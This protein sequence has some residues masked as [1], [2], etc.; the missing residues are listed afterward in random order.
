MQQ[1]DLG[2]YAVSN[3]EFIGRGY[4]HKEGAVRRKYRLKYSSEIPLITQIR[5]TNEIIDTNAVS[6]KGFKEWGYSDKEGV[7]RR[8][9][10]LR[11]KHHGHSADRY[12]YCKCK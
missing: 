7:V 3:K 12:I 1:L 2:L 9:A 6:H 8:S 4:S 10:R 5:N 11:L